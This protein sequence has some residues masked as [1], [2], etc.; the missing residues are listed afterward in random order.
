MKKWWLIYSTLIIIYSSCGIGNTLS[1]YPAVDRNV[2]EAIQKLAKKNNDE[3]LQKTFTLAYADAVL[4]HQNNIISYRNSSQVNKW[5]KVMNEYGYL[6]R[7]ANAVTASPGAAK[8]VVTQNYDEPYAEAK[9][10]AA[11][12]YY[13]K[14]SSLLN[15]NDRADSREAYALLKKTDDL[16]PGYKDVETLQAVASEKSTV[17][18]VINPVNYY[19]QSFGYW[20]LNNDYIQQEIARDLRYQLSST[21]VKVYTDWEARRN[22]IIPDRVV[23]IGW[24]QL[25]IPMP[26]TN[27]FTRQVSKQINTGR[28]DDKKQA[29]YETVSAT[30]YITEKY[31]RAN[32]NLTLRIFDAKNNKQVLWDNFPANYTWREQYATYRGDSR[33]LGGYEL[34]LINNSAYRDP[35]RSDIFSSVLREVYPR[36]VS[37]IRSVTW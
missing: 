8:L 16:V 10:N 9:N 32:G 35:S 12:S 29:I 1:R 31:V 24:D 2:H 25:F 17:Q 34:A 28:V 20:G 7:L 18:I 13:D 21:H 19:S 27:T 11:G 33:A 30:L 23:D 15:S 22:E 14:A 36:L 4:Q 5:E 37:R 3:T 6:I 26:S